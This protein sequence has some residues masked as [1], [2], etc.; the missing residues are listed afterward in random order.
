MLNGKYSLV[1]Y[2]K[3]NEYHLYKSH[4]DSQGKCFLS[5]YVPLC[6][7]KDVSADTSSNLFACQNK[8]DS[9]TKC[10]EKANNGKE[11]CGRCVGRLYTTKS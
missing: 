11:I 2:D 9:R 4:K 1:K 8:N 5:E 6:G 3:T 7:D 10:A